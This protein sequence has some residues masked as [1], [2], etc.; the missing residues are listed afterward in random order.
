MSRSL[1]W[2]PLRR[3][4]TFR[5]ILASILARLQE[6]TMR[7]PKVIK[8]KPDAP[9]AK[10]A[11]SALRKLIADGKAYVDQRGGGSTEGFVRTSSGV[12]SLIE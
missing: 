9:Q 4:F 3:D 12:T 5:G 2:N 6:P 10:A 7:K 1:Q 8:L 11:V